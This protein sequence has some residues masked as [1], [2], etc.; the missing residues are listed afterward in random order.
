MIREAANSTGEYFLE[1]VDTQA[2][3]S[4]GRGY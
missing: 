2:L 4:E 1:E 3:G